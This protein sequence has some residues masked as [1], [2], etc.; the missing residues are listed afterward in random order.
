MAR[1]D[2][3]RRFMDMALALGW[4]QQGLTSPNPSVGSVIVRFDG[5]AP[6]VVGLGATQKG[7]RPH[8]EPVALAM[9][10]EAAR[11]ATMYVSLEP[12]SHHGRAG[13][14]SDAIIAAGVGRVVTGI[15]DPDSRVAGQGHARMRAA[16]LAV[17][18]G[19]RADEAFRM[20]RGHI[21][22]VT[23]GRPL[24]TLKLARTRDGYAGRRD[25]RLR[26]TGAAANAQAHLLRAHADAIMVGAGTI[27]ADNP[28]LTVRLPGLGD[29]SPIRLII[30]SGLH[31]PP[32]AAAV[33]SAREVPT[34]IVT[35]HAAPADAER[36]FSASGV[37][38][39]RVD[40]GP[41]GRVL[42]PQAMALLAQRG[43]ARVLAEGG[44]R[45]AAA[46]ARDDLVDEAILLTGA[47]ELGPVGD[48]DGVVALQP[49]LAAALADPQRFRPLDGGWWGRG[50]ARPDR[51]E[52]F[53][54]PF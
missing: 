7:G 31:T 40:A 29:R 11:G 48:D 38:I 50:H 43:V 19:V 16:G 18:V 54:R 30:D 34:W 39:M 37:E 10:G 53:E 8:G 14:C 1:N 6:V 27:A 51:F 28:Q 44:P 23:Q 2:D 21:L 47:E 9:A 42:L 35:T 46:L 41:D 5:D 15:E 26:I 36:R 33:A 4:R 49:V 20:H 12:C 17:D 24:V 13:P 52:I 25:G 45:L 3:D 32:E 22:R